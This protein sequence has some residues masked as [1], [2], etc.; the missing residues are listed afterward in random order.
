MNSKN[1]AGWLLIIGPIAIF[2]AF[3]GWPSVDTAEEELAE[4]AKNPST[5]IAIMTAFITG[6]L[7]LF[8]GF[9]IS[10]RII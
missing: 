8:T 9:T 10:S 2:S 4:L 7:L 5:S 3:L 6:M 1:L